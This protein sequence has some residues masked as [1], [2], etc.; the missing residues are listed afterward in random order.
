MHDHEYTLRFGAPGP[1]LPKRRVFDDSD[2]QNTAHEPHDDVVRQLTAVSIRL[3]ELLPDPSLSPDERIERLSRVIPTSQLQAAGRR[4]ARNKLVAI[5][6]RL[7]ELVPQFSGDPLAQ[8]QFMVDR[9]EELVPEAGTT[10]QKLEAMGDYRA[11]DIG[12]SPRFWQ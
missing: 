2:Y 9:L 5:R 6:R 11:T 3:I 4:S 7:D 1:P 8:V 10:F 12:V